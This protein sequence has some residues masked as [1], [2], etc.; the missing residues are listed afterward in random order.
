MAEYKY[1]EESVKALME[2]A[3]TA[4][5]PQEL[6]LSEAE[7]IVDVNRYVEANLSDIEAH[8]PDAFYNAAITRLYRLRE[9]IE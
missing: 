4:S 1:D 2:W 6:R 8:Y 9:K 3:R 5:F 7:N